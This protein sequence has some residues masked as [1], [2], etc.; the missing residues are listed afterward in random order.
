M[1]PL[2]ENFSSARLIDVGR[3]VGTDAAKV[4]RKFVDACNAVELS[5]NV[6]NEK[7]RTS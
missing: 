5:I 1:G 3:Q 4:A 2:F 7:Q 6:M